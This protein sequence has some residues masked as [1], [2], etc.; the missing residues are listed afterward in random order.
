MKWNDVFCHTFKAMKTK[1]GP[2]VKKQV[3]FLLPSLP[4]IEACRADDFDF[5]HPFIDADKLTTEQMHNAAERYQLGKTKSGQPIF[6]MIDDMQTPLD[7]HIGTD[8][9]ISTLLKAREPLLKC[10]QVQHCLFGLHLIV[11]TNLTNLTNKNSAISAEQQY[12]CNS[13]HSWAENTPIC[14]VESEQSAVVLS[15]LFPECIWMAYVNT[16]HLSPDLFEPLQDRTVTLYP[17]TDPTLSTF[18]F[19]EDLVDVTRRHYNIDITVDSTLE[20][21]A[22]ADQKD[23]CIDILDFILES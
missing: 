8:A 11:N 21:H 20:D 14:V 9:W 12:S 7:A 10:W 18:L 13:C 23:R 19:F 4:M 17:R 6:W 15:E 22:T 16:L 1:I 3:D 5:F 2:E